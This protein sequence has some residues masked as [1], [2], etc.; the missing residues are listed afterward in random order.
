M[1]AT[2]ETDTDLG[3]LKYLINYYY[4]DNPFLSENEDLGLIA[5]RKFAS[6]IVNTFS[7]VWGKS[8][9]I[10]P[11]SAS[12]LYYTDEKTYCDCT[13]FNYYSAFETNLCPLTTNGSLINFD[14]PGRNML[15]AEY[16][17]YMENEPRTSNGTRLTCVDVYDIE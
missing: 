15:V 16:S 5:I 9:H 11:Q 6:S 17:N 8:G 3:K 1:K 4:S 12:A 13:E 14:L 10:L 7:Y 2:G